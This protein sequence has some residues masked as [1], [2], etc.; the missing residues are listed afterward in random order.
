[1]SYSLSQGHSHKRICGGGFGFFFIDFGHIFM[2]L[3]FTRGAD[4]FGG[5]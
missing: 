1:M 2:H 3:Y 5:F 4:L